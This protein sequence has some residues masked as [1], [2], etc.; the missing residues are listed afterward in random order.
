MLLT[1][2]GKTCIIM[3]ETMND[4]GMKKMSAVASAINEVLKSPTK[5]YTPEEAQL[6][7]R[8]CGIFTK[9]N[10]VKPAYKNIVVKVGDHK[11]GKK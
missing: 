9:N 10:N 5:K 6:K 11:N 3:V 8:N 1:N 4:R 2:G 7:L